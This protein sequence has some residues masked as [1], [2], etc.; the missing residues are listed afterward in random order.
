MLE[1]GITFLITPNVNFGSQR[2]WGKKV[3][4]C[5]QQSHWD[6]R[7]D[8]AE[9]IHLHVYKDFGLLQLS[10]L[11]RDRLCGVL[12]SNIRQSLLGRAHID[13][14]VTMILNNDR[15]IGVEYSIYVNFLLLNSQFK[16]I[17]YVHFS[18]P[19]PPIA[20]LTVPCTL[21]HCDCCIRNSILSTL[22]CLL[23]C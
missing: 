1:H 3:L 20:D 18:Y 9:F 2:T 19:P 13:K 10:H 5:N 7:T 22:W 6:N 11:R 23:A 15:F 21:L 4:T 8:E 12:S 14:E 17:Q 16:L